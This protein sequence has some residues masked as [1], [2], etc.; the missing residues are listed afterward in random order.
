VGAV[1]QGKLG[2]YRVQAVIGQ[3]GFGIV[4]ATERVGAKRKRRNKTRQRVYRGAT[5]LAVKEF[6]PDGIATRD[7]TGRV[8]A[9]P[10]QASA[11]QEALRRSLDELGVLERLKHP[12]ATEV[13]EQFFSNG[14]SYIAME[15]LSGQTLA[16]MIED[17]AGLSA[18]DR[19]KRFEEDTALKIMRGVLEVLAVLHAQKR[20]H[21][22]IKPGNIV[23]DLAQLEYNQPGVELLDFGAVQAFK[24]GERTRVTSRVLTL[25][26][27]PLEQYG[28]HVQL[29]PYTDLYALCATMYE[30]LTGT[31]PPNALERAGGRVLFSVRQLAPFVSKD[32]AAVLE[33]GLA[34]QVADRWQT[35]LVLREELLRISRAR[36][37]ASQPNP[38]PNV[39]STLFQA[40]GALF[41]VFI[42]GFLMVGSVILFI[43]LVLSVLASP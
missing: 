34:L 37:T 1:I 4:Y 33:R 19:A 39:L 16:K 42:G 35:A 25:D 9:L 13:F 23:V 17:G 6:Y 8:V 29:G 22:D 11:L 40:L 21:R 26:Y 7:A 12:G 2:A 43:Y 27:A 38:Q 32:F 3:G 10:G 20:L 14:T 36:D 18:E 28:E 15:L 24:P 41:V 30:Y 5:R 31:K